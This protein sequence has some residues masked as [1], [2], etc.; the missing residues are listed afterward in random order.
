[1]QYAASL[2]RHGRPVAPPGGGGHS[3]SRRAN[4]AE[5]EH[6]Q[7]LLPSTEVETGILLKSTLKNDTCSAASAS[8]PVGTLATISYLGLRL[9]SVSV[10]LTGFGCGGGG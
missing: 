3:A 4:M 10:V 7:P 9:L 6:G 8:T 5:C 2:G 1:M